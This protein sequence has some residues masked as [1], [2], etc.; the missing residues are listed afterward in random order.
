M[1]GYTNI[2]IVTVTGE[3]IFVTAECSLSDNFCYKAGVMHALS[4][5]DVEE[6]RMAGL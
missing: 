1:G 3:D 4:K 5:L 2:H 6:I